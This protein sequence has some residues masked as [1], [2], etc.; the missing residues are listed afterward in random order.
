MEGSTALTALT[1]CINSN[2]IFYSEPAA[3]GRK[4][5]ANSCTKITS[6]TAQYFVYDCSATAC[7]EINYASITA[8]N[9]ILVYHHSGSGG[10]LTQ[11]PLKYYYF[12]DNNNAQANSKL[13]KCNGNI[14]STS[15]YTVVSTAGYYLNPG[16]DSN[17][18][19]GTLPLIECKDAGGNNIKCEAK[20]AT[21]VNDHYLDADTGR[22]IT[23][24][25]TTSCFLEDATIKGYF[26]NSEIADG[27]T[28]GNNIIKCTGSIP[29]TKV[30]GTANPTKIGN[31]KVVVESGVSTTLSFCAE[32][33]CNNPVA[34]GTVAYK[35]ITVSADN[36]FPG[37]K[38]GKTYSIKVGNDGT[39]IML[40]LAAKLPE[41]GETCTKDY[42]CY[43]SSKKIVKTKE[44]DGEDC[45]AITNG[46]AATTTVFFDSDYKKVVSLATGNNPNTMT[47]ICTFTSSGGSFPATLCEHLR[48]YSI[49]DTD[50]IQCSGWKKEGCN[51]ASLPV[52]DCQVGDEGNIDKD[53]E[54]CFGASGISL[55]SSG[56]STIAFNAADINVV[57]GLSKNEVGFMTMTKYGDN[58]FSARIIPSYGKSFVFFFF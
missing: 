3:L 53:K 8:G 7:A 35:T 37:A 34:L 27:A 10:V 33:S 56:S 18:A 51:S 54:I 22:V 16:T 48:G 17:A 15:K 43:D 23:C 45:V 1:Y 24:P 52:G 30:T 39:V 12:H 46:S 38:G 28:T 4:R 11:S 41:C 40:E 57:Y 44:D 21:A 49:G 47:Y 14:E 9:N 55:P 26:R 32:A 6:S 2:D 42:Y 29:C 50:Y 13:L 19:V 25:T 36:D 20:A 58:N 5:A 31:L